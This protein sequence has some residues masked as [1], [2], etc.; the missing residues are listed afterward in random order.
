MAIKEK[1]LYKRGNVY[2][3]RFTNAEGKVV[4]KRLSIDKD[5]ALIMLGTMRRQA[6]M[7]R[8]GIVPDDSKVERIDSCVLLREKYIHHLRLLGRREPTIEIYRL[9]WQYVVEDSGYTTI[10]QINMAGIQKFVERLRNKGTRGQT[11]NYYVHAV[12]RVLSWARDFEYITKNPLARWRGISTDESI[13]RRDM[14]PEEIQNFFR[15]ESDDEYLM[16]WHVYFRTGL[17]V[18]AGLLLRWEWVDWD[19]R[20]LHLPASANKSRKAFDVLLDSELFERLQQWRSKFLE[21]HRTLEGLIFSQKSG[22]QLRRRFRENCVK[23]G[24]DTEGLCLHAIRHTYATNCFE[25]SGYNIKVVQELLC[26]SDG[27]TTM[28]YVHASDQQKRNTVEANALRFRGET[29]QVVN[30]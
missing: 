12:K 2:Y 26:H 13:K 1:G 21:T 24:I 4:R 17:R 6:E 27:A 11:I 23:A 15:A 28:R 29:G 8:A 25:A 10:N 30:Q 7:Q 19:A 3:S 22:G 16:R 9:A 20:T 18:T 14:T 5:A